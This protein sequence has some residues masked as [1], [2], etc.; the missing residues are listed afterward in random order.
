MTQGAWL[1]A[2]HEHSRETSIETVPVPPDGPNEEVEFVTAAWHR[3]LEGPVT[4]V[5]VDAELPQAALKSAL[6]NAPAQRACRRVTLV[7]MHKN[8][9]LSSRI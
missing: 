9:Q 6:I 5:E 7:Q 3:A 2:V 1:T 4:L 8:R